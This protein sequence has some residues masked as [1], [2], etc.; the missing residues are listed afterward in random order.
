M[1]VAEGRPGDARTIKAPVLILGRRPESN[2]RKPRHLRRLPPARSPARAYGKYEWANLC[3][4]GPAQAPPKIFIVPSASAISAAAQI[5][6]VDEEIERRAVF[7][8]QVTA[9][10]IVE[11]FRAAK[12]S[13]RERGKNIVFYIV[14]VQ[15]DH[16]PIDF[17]SCGALAE[18]RGG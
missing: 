9:T 7:L 13:L 16:E 10:L 17:I 6:R 12:I 8:P 15:H 3:A 14:P 18:V 2:K 5:L 1:K 4:V 11:P